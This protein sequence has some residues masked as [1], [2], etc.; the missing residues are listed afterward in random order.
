MDESNQV[1][2]KNTLITIILVILTILSIGLI[3]DSLYDLSYGSS[4]ERLGAIVLLI[5]IPVFAA[6]MIFLKRQCTAKAGMS[7][8]VA[9]GPV[10]AASSP[11]PKTQTR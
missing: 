1:E 2:D 11:N 8:G 6:I 4:S 10:I 5:A 7:K 3:I 9:T